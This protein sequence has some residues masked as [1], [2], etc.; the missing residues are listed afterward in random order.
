MQ[1]PAYVFQATPPRPIK[2]LKIPGTERK[3]VTHVFMNANPLSQK[4]LLKA[5]IRKKSWVRKVETKLFVT[6]RFIKNLMSALPAGSD[7]TTREV[8]GLTP[9]NPTQ[10]MLKTGQRKIVSREN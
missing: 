7:G 9:Y 4:K 8:N 10:K 1:R 6:E 3:L 5:F 2:R